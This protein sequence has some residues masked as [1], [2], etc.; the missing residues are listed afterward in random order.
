MQKK[1]LLV[2][3][4]VAVA[5]GLIMVIHGNFRSSSLEGALVRLGGEMPPGGWE[6]VWG[7]IVGLAGGLMMILGA[8]RKQ[9]PD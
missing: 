7:V 6:M 2:L 3:G 5:V 1:Q 8:L 4:A 9:K